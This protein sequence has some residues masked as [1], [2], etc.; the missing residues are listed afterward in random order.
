[1]HTVSIQ[2]EINLSKIL[3][4]YSFLGS[5]H[6]TLTEGEEGLSTINHYI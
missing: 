4:L 5:K 2:S 3:S 6:G 1:M